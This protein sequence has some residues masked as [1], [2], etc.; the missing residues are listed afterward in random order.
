MLEFECEEVGEAQ[1]NVLLLLIYYSRQYPS[2]LLY[3]NDKHAGRAD[4]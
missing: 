1:G 3:I 2:C 4:N